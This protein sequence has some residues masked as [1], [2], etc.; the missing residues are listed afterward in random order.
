M[1][2]YALGKL[3]ASLG[4]E[5]IMSADIYPSIFSRQM[6][7]TVYLSFDA[8]FSSLPLADSPPR[9]LQITAYK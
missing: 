9:D 6:E 3:F 7:T 2:N 1:E 8:V 5:Q 4:P